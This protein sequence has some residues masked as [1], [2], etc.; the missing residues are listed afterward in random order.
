MGAKL[1]FCYTNG[2]PVVELRLTLFCVLGDTWSDAGME[3]TDDS[4]Y[5]MKQEARSSMSNIFEKNWTGQINFYKHSS[6][7]HWYPGALTPGLPCCWSTTSVTQL[8]ALRAVLQCSW[9]HRC[10]HRRPFSIL[11]LLRTSNEWMHLK[12]FPENTFPFQ[13]AAQLFI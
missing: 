9:Q 7:H 5:G 4:L 10:T 11:L 6:L 2:A 12:D 13:L 3:L 8:T 1:H